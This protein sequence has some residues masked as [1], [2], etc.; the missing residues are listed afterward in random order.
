MQKRIVSFLLFIIIAPVFAVYAGVPGQGIVDGRMIGQNAATDNEK[1]NGQNDYPIEIYLEDAHF[2]YSAEGIKR[3]TFKRKY[4]ILNQVGASNWNYVSAAWYPWYQERPVITARVISP[5]G[6]VTELDPKTVGEVSAKQNSPL[7]YSDRKMIKGPLPAIEVGCIVEEE[8][9]YQDRSPFIKSGSQQSY[10]F[11]GTIPIKKSVVKIDL[12]E[13]MPFRFKLHN[14]D[15]KPLVTSGDGYRYYT[16]EAKDLQAR[17]S[18][19]LYTLPENLFWSSLEFSTVA[20]WNSVAREYN[21]KVEKQLG[22]DN[23][24]DQLMKKA[25][26]SRGNSRADVEELVRLLHAEIRYTG[27]EFGDASIV[28]RSPRE[29]IERKYGDCKDKAVLLVAMLRKA[30]IKARVALL[31]AGHDRDV[32]RDIPGMDFFNHAIVYIPAPLDLWIDATADFTPVGELPAVDQERFAL[33]ID[34]GTKD[35]VRTPGKKPEQNTV[36]FK[37]DVYLSQLGK[38]KVMET[39][40][41][42]GDF[43]SSSRAFYHEEGRESLTKQFVEYIK[44]NFNTESY[45]KFDYTTPVDLKH[46]F[47]YSFMIPETNYGYTDIDEAGTRLDLSFF[48]SKF[49]EELT[50]FREFDEVNV[51]EKEKSPWKDRDCDLLIPMPHLYKLI[52]AVHIPPGFDLL[53]MPENREFKIGETVFSYSFKRTEN[54]VTAEYSV[55]TGRGRYSPDQ[56]K[57]LRKQ[58]Y[59]IRKNDTLELKF[60]SQASRFHEKGEIDKSISYYKDLVARYS[61]EPGNY[62]RLGNIILTAGFRDASIEYYKKAVSLN[63]KSVEANMA[64]AWAY[65]HDPFGRQLTGTIEIEKAKEVYGTV[66][67]LDPTIAN[68]W[69]NLAILWEY[70]A[71]GNRYSP[72]ADYKKSREYY[73]HYRSELKNDDL[74]FN[75][76]LVL[77]H[78]GEYDKILEMDDVVSRTGDAW[79]IYLMAMAVRKG[80]DPVWE[81][82]DSITNSK[83]KR[84][85]ILGNTAN[86]LAHAR[87]YALTSDLLK[88]LSGFSSNSIEHRSRAAYT[89]KLKKWES[90]TVDPGSPVSAVYRH[91]KANYMDQVDEKGVRELYSAHALKLK[92]AEDRLKEHT[93]TRKDFIRSVTSDR[94]NYLNVF[95]IIYSNMNFN[96]SGDDGTGYRIKVTFDF[97]D[98]QIKTVYYVVREGGTYRVLDTS[99]KFPMGLALLALAHTKEK[100]Y[101]RATQVLDWVLEFEQLSQK[102]DIRDIPFFSL[103]Q[104]GSNDEKRIMISI[105]LL[106][107][108]LREYGPDLLAMRASVTD[109]EWLYQIDK[110]LLVHYMGKEDYVKA[111]P[112]VERIIQ[113]KGFEKDILET[114][115]VILAESGKAATFETKIKELL[116]KEP[117]NADYIQYYSNCR[118]RQGDLPGAKKILKD[119]HERNVGNAQTYNLLAWMGLFYDD[120]LDE[121]L[122]YAIIS[123]RLSN[124]SI[125]A[126][127]HTM[128]TIYADMGKITE[129]KQVI[130]K[131]L[132]NRGDDRV[133][134]EDHYVLGR[135][136]ETLGL[137]DI[138]RYHYG[139]IKKSRDEI[140]E[141]AVYELAVRRLKVLD[142]GKKGQ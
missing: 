6:R 116:D 20:D 58:L 43:A 127:L 56:L 24:V 32:M 52:Y 135:N 71:D 96:V 69:R 126:H 95:D 78:A 35:L 103:W 112:V 82:L 64:L 102:R 87:Y 84:E 34:E 60:V 81:K 111:L 90:I 28:P 36:L 21:A 65:L 74:D 9:V 62:I 77:F 137:P 41:V 47:T 124:F 38:S 8:Y 130:Y 142:D 104:R 13:K 61:N 5:E 114:Y 23:G 14:L 37:R 11:N 107:G 45:E 93:A 48:I 138:A 139:Q 10:R 12:P 117:D 54:D 73:E 118:I 86:Y 44:N 136:A 4:R 121:L 72:F 131:M 26:K 141:L 75:Y 27:V 63:A 83:E 19:P 51:A 39:Y 128:A 134:E 30:G 108:M 25:V 16:F 110:V 109:D 92:N 7:L 33:I 94:K 120:S 97:W 46:P 89:G 132:E 1:K 91:V 79:P 98:R 101:A 31:S 76:L 59:E 88:K 125:H 66:V 18:S 106:L 57:Q 80:I 55:N 123:N 99:D 67:K 133:L 140:G 2:R 115:Y 40:T 50:D 22:G 17:E 85:E 3:Y 119:A 122:N 68:A 100:Q 29:V 70:D 105:Y 129:S 15:V 49:P 113:K 42:T 53:Q